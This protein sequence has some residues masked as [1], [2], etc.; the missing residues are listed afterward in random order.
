MR[1]RL[2]HLRE[3]QWNPYII[4]PLIKKKINLL[5]GLYKSIFYS[6]NRYY[7][8]F[9]FKIKFIVVSPVV[10]MHQRRTD[11]FLPLWRSLQRTS[12]QP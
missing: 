2:E 3:I 7:F 1:R 11:P 4:I 8:P 5:F 6:E 9:E 12:G 10:Q